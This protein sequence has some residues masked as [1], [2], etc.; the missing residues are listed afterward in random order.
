MIHA[1][2]WGNSVIGINRDGFQRPMSF[3]GIE[4]GDWS[5]TKSN[6]RVYYHINGLQYNPMDVLH[7]RWFSI[8]GICGVSAI[9]M[10]AIL[11]GK[12]FKQER[13][14]TYALGARPPGYLSNAVNLTKENQQ[15]NK[16]NWKK[17]Q[18]SGE[19]PVL[20]GDW[21]WNNTMIPPGDA[22]YLG[23]ASLTE[24]QIYGVF[25]MPPA[26][27]QNYDRMT[28]NNAEQADLVYAKHTITPIV[29]VI[30]QECNMKLF[31][32]REK[33]KTYVKFNMN[34]LLRGD[35][36]ARA[37]FYTAMRNIGGINGDEI[38]E[39]EDKNPYKGGDI[40]T[41]QGANVPIDQLRD[42]YASK[43]S[44]PEPQQPVQSDKKLNGI[45]VN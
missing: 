36:K 26:F 22:E 42:F 39:F 7:F 5:V 27:A 37:E 41:I 12:N 35:L 16:E 29:R 8:D 11:M 19:T 34:G 3:E 44:Q 21:K 32:D 10:N 28:W 43:V 18:T 20:I 4:P 6:G 23:T 33:K 1:D 40:F 13:Y 9:R 30:E 45:H 31:T 38:R 15:Q 17:A 14:S 24:R 2:G 25:Q